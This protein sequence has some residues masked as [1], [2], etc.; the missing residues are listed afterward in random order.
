MTLLT[1]T[2]TDEIASQ[3]D[4]GFKCFWNLKSNKLLF[5][6]DQNN[7][8]SDMEFW[9]DEKAEIENNFDEFI[10]VEK[11]SSEYFFRLMKEFIETNI[12]N[13]KLKKELL[14][15]LD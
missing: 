2:E 15:V 4:C 9:K 13:K 14:L 1:K 7:D 12:P 3:F 11:P 10:V 6:P 5:I 8:F